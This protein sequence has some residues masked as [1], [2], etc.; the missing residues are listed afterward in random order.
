M[1]MGA[2][3]IIAY[4]AQPTL[5]AGDMEQR[6][7]GFEFTEGPVW[8]ADGALLFSDI[9]A[10]TIYVLEDGEQSVFRRPSG[11]SNGLTLDREGRLL[12][13]EHKNRRV[14]R[15]EADGTITVVAERY[16]GKRFNSP[17][18]LVVRSGGTIFFTDPP[19]GLARQTEDPGKEIDFQGVYRVNK[20]GKAQLLSRE[21][22][23]PN[24]IAFSPDEKTLYVANSHGPRPI[25]MAF[26]VNDKGLLENGRVFFDS[27]EYRRKHPDRQGGDDGMAVDQQ[28]NIYAT[29]AGGVIIL[30]PEGEHLGTIVTG[31]RTA[32]CTFGDDGHTLYITADMYLARIRLKTKGV[33][34]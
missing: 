31:E 19:Y 18:D 22:E 29:T 21:L 23:R 24:G 6:A 33:G 14:T 34:F 25:W 4:S 17:N 9:P 8:R 32:N 30:S 5:V 27:T 20:Q 3:L 7:D 28:G 13:A 26:D 15:T 11:E 10:D 1:L 2:L 16:D 12:A